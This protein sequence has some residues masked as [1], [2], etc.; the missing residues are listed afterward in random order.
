MASRRAS[1]LARMA[2]YSPTMRSK[3]TTP[4]GTRLRKGASRASASV[5]NCFAACAW[6]TR[7]ESGRVVGGVGWGGR[8][9]GGSRA[10]FLIQMG[11]RRGARG[12]MRGDDDAVD[13]DVPSRNRWI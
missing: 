10:L 6:M 12:G 4:V 9:E 5:L 2:T 7:G 8:S 13:M 11:T 1:S 3:P